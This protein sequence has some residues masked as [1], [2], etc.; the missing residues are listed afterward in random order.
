MWLLQGVLDNIPLL[1]SMTL[2]PKER[3][4]VQ[5]LVTRP[6]PPFL[7]PPPCLRSL[8][9]LEALVKF[10]WPNCSVVH[11]MNIKQIL[12]PKPFV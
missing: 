5:W 2:R 10:E 3:Y 11:H 6:Q 7:S 4:T 9:F 1:D 8:E 12:A